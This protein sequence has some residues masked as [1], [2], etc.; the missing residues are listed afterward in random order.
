MVSTA[1]VASVLNIHEHQDSLN[2]SFVWVDRAARSLRK[3]EV[4]TGYLAKRAKV[5]GA[6]ALWSSTWPACRKSQI[7]PL[8]PPFKKDADLGKTAAYSVQFPPPPPLSSLFPI[9]LGN[10]ISPHL[11]QSWLLF[12]VIPLGLYPYVAQVCGD[13]THHI[14]FTAMP[15]IHSTAWVQAA[16][17]SFLKCLLLL[18][19]SCLATA[20]VRKMAKRGKRRINGASMGNLL[21]MVSQKCLWQSNRRP[22]KKDMFA[23]SRLFCIHVSMCINTEIHSGYSAYTYS[24]NLILS[25]DFP[26]LQIKRT[27]WLCKQVHQ[28]RLSTAPVYITVKMA[29]C[30]DYF[31]NRDFVIV[32]LAPLCTFK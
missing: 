25:L 26:E 21:Q 11:I 23:L 31:L 1:L 18:P 19:F 16:T 12:V 2:C 22:A 24:C 17:P 6:F 15:L 5:E 13:Y 28:I 10:A 14:H 20:G 27:A 9:Q 8:A 29:T 7:Q 4:R 3:Q 32:I 30:R